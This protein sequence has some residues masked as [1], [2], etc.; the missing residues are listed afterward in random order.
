[1]IIFQCS[2]CKVTY[3]V[4]SKDSDLH[5]LRGE[6]CCPNHPCKGKIVEIAKTNAKVR[7]VK[8]RAVELYQAHQMGFASERKCGPKELAKILTGAKVLSVD[9]DKSQDPNKS[10]IRSLTLEGGKTIH[11]APST[12]GVVVLKV[13]ERRDV[14]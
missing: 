9:I 13:T 2:K 4:S 6:V 8:V 3:S 12:L 5:L 10:I 11:L 14:R 7:A 1:M